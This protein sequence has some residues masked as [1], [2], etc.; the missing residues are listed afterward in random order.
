[1]LEFWHYVEIE[2]LLFQPFILLAFSVMKQ[3][4]WLE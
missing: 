4:G 2:E 1:L 3:N